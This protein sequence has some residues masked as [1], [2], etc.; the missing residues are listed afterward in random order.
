MAHVGYL[1]HLLVRRG[2]KTGEIL[3]DLVTSTQTE[4]PGRVNRMRKRCL[5]AGKKNFWNWIWKVLLPESS[6]QKTTA[7]RM[8]YRM[9][10]R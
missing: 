8:W 7:S 5:R 4:E 3:V 10:A 6:T 9:T 1:R 2:V